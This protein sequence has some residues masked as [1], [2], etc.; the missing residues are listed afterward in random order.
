MIPLI[1]VIICLS[2]NALL[3]G[4]EMAFVSVGRP[5][6]KILASRGWKRAQTLLRL[7][8]NPE[9]ILSVIQIGITLVG[10][11]AAAVSGAGAEEAF[12]PWLQTTF[13][14]SPDTANAVAIGL[15]VLPLTYFNVVFGE[16]IPKTLSLRH[17][18]RIAL[19]AAPWLSLFD[20]G[21][22]PIVS[23]LEKSTKFFLRNTK[24]GEAPV[25]V[26]GQD[27]VELENLRVKTKEYV[28][29]LIHA[30]KKRAQDVM[31]P[32]AETQHIT[33]DLPAS[34]IERQ[35]MRT[36]HTRLPVKDGD[37]VVGLVHAKEFMNLRQAGDHEWV[38]SVRL[39][40]KVRALDPILEILPK[41][42]LQKSHMAAVYDRLQL[43][44]IV[45]L[46]DIVEEIVG[47]I[48]DE[49]D[50]GR[51]ARLLASRRKVR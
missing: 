46:E 30:E 9:R 41:M 36:G 34:E 48:Y 26:E 22:S 3:A 15:V 6:I 45:T 11:V 42:Q 29:K 8:L 7:K 10:A 4:A 16:L 19:I 47:D 23:L 33:T 39:M 38:S 20:R 21:L 44:G 1:I 13:S 2:L 17:P 18:L 25:A 14:L 32:W 50:D 28:L 37:D 31:I 40:L 5:Q 35:I 51:V 43:V 49:D 24:P 27:F 12:G